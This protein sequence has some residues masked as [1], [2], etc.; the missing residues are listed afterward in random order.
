MLLG[1]MRWEH[2]NVLFLLLLAAYFIYLATTL[3]DRG[4]SLSNYVHG[5]MLVVLGAAFHV[6]NIF[7]V[8]LGVIA[9]SVIMWLVRE[10]TSKPIFTKPEEHDVPTVKPPTKRTDE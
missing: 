9:F 6:L 5:I 4:A 2:T 10:K 3:E 1:G 7:L 8:G